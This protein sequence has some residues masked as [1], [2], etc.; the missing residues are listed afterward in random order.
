MSSQPL[1]VLDADV[2]ISAKSTY[3]GF[4]ICP[5]FWTWLERLHQA[6]QICSI[7]RV[8]DEIVSP[9]KDELVQ[10]ATKTIPRAFFRPVADEAIVSEFQRIITWVNGR[11]NLQPAASAKFA[12]GADGWLVAFAT[13]HSAV[14]VTNEQPRPEAKREVKLPDVCNQFNVPWCNTFQMLKRLG[15]AM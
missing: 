15:V 4:D 9:A 12:T 13:V 14:V 3:Y 6:G 8:R 1:Y 7:D 11:S 5:S 10:W 2:F